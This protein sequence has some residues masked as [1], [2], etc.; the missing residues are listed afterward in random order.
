MTICHPKGWE[1]EGSDPSASRNRQSRFQGRQRD[2]R[3]SPLTALR[4]VTAAVAVLVV[5][6][7][8]GCAPS[9]PSSSGPPADAKSTTPAAGRTPTSSPAQSAQAQ[10]IAFLP[11][12]LRMLDDLYLDPSRPLNDIYQVAVTP[13]AT[14]EATAIGKFRAQGY[15]QTGRSQLVTASAK[16]VDLATDSATSPSPT[17][18]SVVVKAC[19]DVSQVDALDPSGTSVVPPTRP[20]YLIEQ[21]TVVNPHYPAAA[22]WRVSDAANSQAQTCGG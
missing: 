14:T 12:Y 22:G 10:A 9:E 8:S 5:L 20:K 16:N 19:V 3:R 13:D 17:P 11:T 21:W 1:G 7:L 2:G 6:A 15:R 18:P 4:G